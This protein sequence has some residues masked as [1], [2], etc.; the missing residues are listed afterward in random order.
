MVCHRCIIAV[1]NILEKLDIPYIEVR[2]GEVVLKKP[3]EQLELSALQE[4]LQKIGFELLEDRHLQIVENI[5]NS[6]NTAFWLYKNVPKKL[7]YLQIFRKN[8]IA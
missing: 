5:K 6:I 1:E 4:E 2:L 8:D 3:K 7:K